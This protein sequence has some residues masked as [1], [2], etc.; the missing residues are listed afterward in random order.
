VRADNPIAG[1]IAVSCDD[2]AWPRNVGFHRRNV[3]A[4]RQAFPITDGMP[5]NLCPCAFWLYRPVESPVRVTD[6]GPRNILI[7]QN[8]R[9]PATP[10]ITGFGLRTVRGR[11]AVMLT[12]DAGHAAYTRSA[13]ASSAA[14]TFLATGRLPRDDQS[15]TLRPAADHFHPAHVP[16]LDAGGY[17]GAMPSAPASYPIRWP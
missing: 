15:A 5:T 6:H 9:D 10:W 11:R 14:D 4:D 16:R 7:L 12:V 13:C 8:L 1:L 2:V 3:A 17:R